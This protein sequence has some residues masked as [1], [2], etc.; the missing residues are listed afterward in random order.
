MSNILIVD[1]Q[2]ENLYLS[3][4]LLE[5]HG[6]HVVEATNG[7]E[8]LTLARRDPPSL[9]IT[10]IMMPAMDGLA[11]CKEW[12][13]DEKLKDIPF[14]FYTATYTDPKDE[15]LAL[16]LGASR[17]II[18]PVEPDEF[19]SILRQVIRDSEAGVLA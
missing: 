17:F 5:G 6:Y 7:A 13:I 10:D 1:D 18:K 9:I 2:V 11:I 3:K 8:A 19:I 4:S 14:I 15:E 16:S 12:K